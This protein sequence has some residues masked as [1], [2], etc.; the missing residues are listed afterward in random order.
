MILKV[1]LDTKQLEELKDEISRALRNSGVRV[2]DEFAIR[3]EDDIN[4]A[5]RCHISIPVRDGISMKSLQALNE[6][7]EPAS[8][9]YME[10]GDGARLI[11]YSVPHENL[12]VELRF[13]FDK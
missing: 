13:K 3:I 12:G 8:D 9:P 11:L 4:N 10:T 7:F 2:A 5:D 6:H 1:K